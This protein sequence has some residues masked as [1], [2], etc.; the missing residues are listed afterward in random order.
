M[1]KSDEFSTAAACAERCTKLEAARNCYYLMIL[2]I[3]ELNEYISN[4]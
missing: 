4:K 3:A 1:L 2:S